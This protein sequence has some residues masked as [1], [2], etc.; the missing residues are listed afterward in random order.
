[1]NFP[2]FLERKIPKPIDCWWFMGWWPKKTQSNFLN[3]QAWWSTFTRDGEKPGQMVWKRKESDTKWRNPCR[4][5]TGPGL[6]HSSID[7][8]DFKQKE[9]KVFHFDVRIQSPGGTERRCCRL[10]FPSLQT[11]WMAVLHTELRNRWRF[12]LKKCNQLNPANN[13]MNSHFQKTSEILNLSCRRISYCFD[14]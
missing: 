1:M 6:V 3:L 13:S 4:K 12:F 5:P 14:Q 11:L 9:Q 2:G 7:L 10:Y 8:I